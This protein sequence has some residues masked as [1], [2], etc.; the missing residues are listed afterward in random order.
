MLVHREVIDAVGSSDS[1]DRRDKFSHDRTEL[2]TFSR[3]HLAE[4]ESMSSG[5]NDYRSH[6][7]H[8]QGSVLYEEVFP[9]DNVAP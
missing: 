8:L 4:I 7:R 5:L 2:S 3:S 1:F 9:F 6:M